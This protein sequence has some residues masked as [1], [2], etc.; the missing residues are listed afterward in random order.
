[1]P[2]RLLHFPRIKEAVEEYF[3]EMEHLDTLFVLEDYI[4][5]LLLLYIYLF[6]LFDDHVADTNA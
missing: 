2:V 1:M 3:L 6:T 4:T 5:S